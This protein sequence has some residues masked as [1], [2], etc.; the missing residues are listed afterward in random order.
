MKRVTILAVGF[1]LTMGLSQAAP[2]KDPAKTYA[3]SIGD[4]MCGGPKWTGAMRAAGN[5]IFRYN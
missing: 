5:G 3:G 4:S 1:L 2:G